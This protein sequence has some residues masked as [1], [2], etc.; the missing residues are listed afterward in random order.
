LKKEVFQYRK[1]N[2]VINVFVKQNQH[3]MRNKSVYI[4]VIFFAVIVHGFG[5]QDPQFTQHMYTIL[6][7][8]PGMAG[9]AGICASL[10][11][12][13]QWVGFNDIIP[14][15][16]GK[17]D[18]FKTSPRDIMLTLHAPVKKLHGGL[19]LTVYNDAY[20]YQSDITVKLAYSFRMNIG[21]GV[22]GIGPSFDLLSRKIQQN[23]WYFNP[24]DLDE[25][26]LNNMAQ[27]GMY[28]SIA[29]GAHFEMQNKWYAGLSCT[30]LAP[31][32][33]EKSLKQKQNQHI[34]AM[35]G[36]S[37]ELPS[38]PN[39]VF[40]PCALLKTDLKAVQVD[41]TFIAEWQD[42]FWAGV[43]YRTIDAVAVLGGARPFIANT[44][45]YLRGLEV[46]VSYDVTTSKLIKFG[47][48]FGS[49][50]ISLKYCFKI[51]I[52]PP[53]SGHRGTRLLGNRPIEYR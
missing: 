43:S 39:W 31:I 22:L 40:K 15:L 41:A 9:S 7:I 12:R 17:E 49:P 21:G 47:R 5:Q 48:S 26:I 45:P 52:Q 36:Y 2:R 29:L 46:A 24:Q 38:N 16:S 13:Q 18:T 37:F 20:G 14:N 3:F 53:V 10:H 28:F 34:Y 25:T 51:Y 50:E 6:P 1:R 30:Q 42:M 32:V 19:G 23:H 27:T 11:Y 33:D 35:G 8:N 44:S 4:F